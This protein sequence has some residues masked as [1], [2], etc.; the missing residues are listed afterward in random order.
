MNE[1]FV[2]VAGNVVNEPET[3]VARNGA[4]FTT[5]RLASTERRYDPQRKGFVDGSTSYYSVACW[6]ALGLNVADSLHKGQPVVVTGRQRVN[7]WESSNGTFGTSVE[8]EASHVGHDLALGRTSFE[9]GMR[10]GADVT[11]RMAD[12]ALRASMAELGF[13]TS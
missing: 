12:P 7:Q 4:P 13:S 8:I 2:T 6:R 1:T 3:R 11:G 10:A 5:F 9:K